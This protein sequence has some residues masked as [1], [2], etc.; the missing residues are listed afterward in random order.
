MKEQGGALAVDD[1][2]VDGV[3]GRAGQRLAGVFRVDLGAAGREVALGEDRRGRDVLRTADRRRRPRRRRRRSSAPRS[4]RARRRRRRRARGRRGSPAPRDDDALARRRQLE[5]GGAGEPAPI[6]STQE[7][8]GPIGQ[9]GGPQRAAGVG[10]GF[11][12]PR[13]ERAAVEGV[14]AARRD[15][16]RATRPARERRSE[17]RRRE[18]RR[19]PGR[20]R[21]RPC[22]RGAARLRPTLRRRTASPRSR[23]AP[24][25]IA[26]A[27]AASIPSR[28]KRPRSFSQASTE[29]GMVTVQGPASGISANPAS[30][31]A[32]RVR[33]AAPG[34]A[35][36][37]PIGASAPVGQ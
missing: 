13:P 37:R 1:A 31:R 18:G 9:V 8:P 6:G 26:G 3:G 12:D 35:P 7:A 10:A 28:P 22:R 17:S 2:E 36:S 4:R 19:P 11:A 16:R 5:D 33:P 20:S 25:S 29:P 27:S 30:R 23:R 21:S 15:R 32:S 24:A 14:G 34:P